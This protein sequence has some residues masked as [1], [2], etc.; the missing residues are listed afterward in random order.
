MADD[1]F[2]DRH[3][4]LNRK[5]FLC[6]AVNVDNK[7]LMKTYSTHVTKESYCSTYRK[8]SAQA[9]SPAELHISP[10]DDCGENMWG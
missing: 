5:L 1:V 2:G 9:S 7:C 4:Q 8:L 10:E 3:L 6:E